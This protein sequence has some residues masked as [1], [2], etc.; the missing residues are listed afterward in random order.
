MGRKKTASIS[1]DFRAIGD[2]RRTD[3]AKKVPIGFYSCRTEKNK[4]R[5]ERTKTA[6]TA[7]FV[8]FK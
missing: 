7:V 8:L 5:V 2:R 6:L 4:H 3:P 1:Q